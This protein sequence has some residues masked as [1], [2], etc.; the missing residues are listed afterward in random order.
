MVTYGSD[1]YPKK[2]GPFRAGRAWLARALGRGLERNLVQPCCQAV[3]G[4]SASRRSIVAV[5]WRTALR[6]GERMMRRI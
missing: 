5:A 2:H 1:A 3:A 6:F 4:A